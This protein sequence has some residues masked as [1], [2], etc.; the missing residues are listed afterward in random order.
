MHSTLSLR[1]LRRFAFLLGGVLLSAPLGSAAVNAELDLVVGEPLFLG[2]ETHLTEPLYSWVLSK[3]NQIL[4]TQA[5]K[6]FRMTPLQEGMMDLALTIRAVEGGEEKHS[7]PLR[8][9][10]RVE[11]DPVTSNFV[12]AVIRAEPPA[13]GPE[14]TVTLP[15]GGGI[16]TLYLDEST[17]NI[18][19]YRIDSNITFDSDGDGVTDNDMENSVHPS[20]TTGG[21][22]PMSIVPASGE[23]ERIVQL[24]VFGVNGEVSEA[25]IRVLFDPSVALTPVLRTL[26]P[27]EQNDTLRLPQEGGIVRFDATGTSGGAIRYAFDLDHNHDTDRDTHPKN[28]NDFRGTSFELIGTEVAMLLRPNAGATERRISLTAFNAVGEASTRTFTLIFGDG[29]TLLPEDAPPPVGPSLNAD[30]DLLNVGSPFTLRVEGA[31]FQTASYAWDLQSDGAI[32]TE[33]IEPLLLLEPDAPG[34]LPVRVLLRDANGETL[35]TASREFSVHV[36]G[37]EE[38]TDG[39]MPLPGG[40]DEL[41]IDVVTKGLIAF[42]QPVLR[43]GGNFVRF[44]PTWDFGDGSMSYLLTPVHEY[45]GSGTYEVKLLLTDPVSGR[46]AASAVMTVSAEGT[47]VTEPIAEP[48]FFGE[49]LRTA[50]FIL[51]VVLFVLFLLLLFTGGVIVYAFLR[52]KAEGVPLKDVL[53]SY[54]RKLSGVSVTEE[55]SKSVPEIIGAASLRKKESDEP[56]PMKLVAE[57]VPKKAPPPL[58]PQPPKTPVPPERKSSPPAAPPPA[59]PKAPAKAPESGTLGSEKGQLP[60][61][62]Q[63]EEKPSTLPRSTP[64]QSMTPSVELPPQPA[65]PVVLPTVPPQPPLKQPAT[66]SDPAGEEMP[67]WL[68]RGMGKMQEGN[69]SATPPASKPVVP[70]APLPPA[71]TTLLAPTSPT[72]LIKEAVPSSLLPPPPAEIPDDEPIAMLRAELPEEEDQAA[73]PTK[74]QPIPKEQK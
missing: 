35:A 4:E 30:R 50:G 66:S 8:I 54:K 28:D 67:S 40:D 10:P 19:E 56:A 72:L 15:L 1:R 58:P 61:W 53:L 49:F 60:S 16:I 47:S 43:D 17:G 65:T 39:T 37:E 64:A 32:D 5:E 23:R 6:F 12:R 13:G 73:P 52:A 44:Y 25:R 41:R 71:S 9:A 42:F 26:P 3:D 38:N 33:T 69:G 68:K 45:E 29:S 22:F 46:E 55:A 59:P 51:K 11:I 34:M 21:S 18:R 62:L 36:E 27:M 70:L 48:G 63:T 20:F 7:F 74:E 57:E 14:K 2:V 24:R 31:P